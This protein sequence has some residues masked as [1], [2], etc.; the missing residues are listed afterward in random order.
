MQSFKQ[1]ALPNALQCCT[2]EVWICRP[3]YTKNPRLYYIA[4][5]VGMPVIWINDSGGAPYTG[6]S[7]FS[8]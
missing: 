6:G 2:V 8:G 5:K 1:E 7:G 3:H 4:A